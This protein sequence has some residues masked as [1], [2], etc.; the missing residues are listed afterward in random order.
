MAGPQYPRGDRTAGEPAA[1]LADRAEELCRTYLPGGKR[2]GRHW[3]VGSVAGEAG[4]SLWVDLRGNDRGRWRDEAVPDHKG[5]MLDLIAAAKGIDLPAAMDEAARFL[6]LPPPEPAANAAEGPFAAMLR[7]SLPVTP[8]DPAG[9]YLASRGLAAGDAEGCRFH[10]I[11]WVRIDGKVR[12]EPALIVPLT[13]ADGRRQAVHRIFVSEEAGRRRSRGASGPAAA[14]RGWRTRNGWSSAR[15]SRSRAG[16]NARRSMSSPCGSSRIGARPSRM[17][18]ATSC[19]P[20]GTPPG[21]R[22]RP[23]WRRRPAPQC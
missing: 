23:A 12:E 1:M 10:P 7:D 6:G 3:R 20:A 16:G 8:D 15:A 18:A 14:A 13:D 19:G 11:L 5:D 22:T 21:G 2:N 9:R 4:Q 17:E